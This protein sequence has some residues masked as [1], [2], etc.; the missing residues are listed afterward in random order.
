MPPGWPGEVAA[1]GSPGWSRS[2]AA[3]LLDQCPPEYRGYPVLRQHPVVLAWLAGYHV[4]GQVE[5]T[6]RALAG[7]RAG[8]RDVLP[9]AGAEAVVEAAVEA[10]EREQARLAGVSRALRLVE[11]ALQGH[12]YVPRL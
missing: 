7:A 12:E 3:W 6:R 1:P 5:A 11:Q 8:L 10:I 9:R 2:A 4:A